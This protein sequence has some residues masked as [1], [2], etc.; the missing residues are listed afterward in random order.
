MVSLTSLWLPILVAAVLVFFASSLIHMVLP[1]HRS[2]Y[3]KLPQEDRVM[4][5][6]RPFH[7]SPGDYVVPRPGT[8]AE[9]K[10]PEF[11][12]KLR[13]G[14]VF[15]MTVFPSGAPQMGAQ[16]AQWFLYCV[17]VSLFAAYITSRALGPGAA[18]LDVSQFAS[19]TAFAAYGLALWQNTIWYKRRWT[20][21]LK[22]NIDSLIYG[23]LTGGVFGW[24]WPR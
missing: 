3:D 9:M 13:K 6:L 7:L 11:G 2:D 16:L 21:T 5:A 24:L 1:Y 8:P 10:T 20:T 22:S 18:Y 14:P 19:T 12:D 17:V 15:M 23:F 4:D